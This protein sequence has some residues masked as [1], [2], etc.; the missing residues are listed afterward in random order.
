MRQ[1]PARGASEVVEKVTI[2]KGKCEKTKRLTLH[3]F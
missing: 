3:T 2:K 1:L